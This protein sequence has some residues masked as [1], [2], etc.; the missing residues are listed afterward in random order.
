MDFTFQNY[1]WGHPVLRHLVKLQ[2]SAKNRGVPEDIQSQIQNCI[3]CVIAGED[4]C[5]SVS[6][7]P[8]AAIDNLIKE[9]ENHPWK[10]AYEGGELDWEVSPVMLS[11]ALEGS[12]LKTLTSIANAKRV[13]EVGLFTGCAALAIAEALPADGK[14]ISCEIGKYVGDVARKLVDQSPHGK[15]IDIMIGPASESLQQLA[16]E[17]QKFDMVFID[18]NKEGYIEYYNIIMDNDLLDFRGTILIDNTF[19]GGQSYLSQDKLE[20]E[21]DRIEINVMRGFN[22]H[23]YNDDRVSQVLVPI[24]DGVTIIRRKAEFEGEV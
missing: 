19:H 21:E 1:S 10:Q 14:V 20:L 16:T 12:F 24:R 2:E 8:S 22:D 3:D 9:T 7:P 4:Y 15:K 5:N 6:S 17:G 11:G 23:V 13:L 18:A